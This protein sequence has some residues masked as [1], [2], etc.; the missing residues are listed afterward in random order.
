ML[1]TF[2]STRAVSSTSGSLGLLILRIGFAVLML[3]HGIPKL[4]N[5][6]T[7]SAGFDPIGLGGTFSLSLVVFAEVFCSIGIL[8]GLLTR[9]A[10]IPLIINMLVAVLVI[11][12]NDPLATKELALLYLLAFTTI[13][14]AG[15]GK[16]SIDR[17]LW[18]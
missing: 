2:F 15:P 7:M 12:S 18:K 8:V 13:L 9:A 4:S 16:Y 1:R 14:F 11:H 10:A 6:S 5:F 17:Y 3:T